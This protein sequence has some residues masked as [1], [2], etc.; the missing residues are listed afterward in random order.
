MRAQKSPGWLGW[1]PLVVLP[2]AACTVRNQLAPWQFM[3]LLSFA[4]FWGFKFETW[5][6]ARGAAGQAG[7]ARNLGY[8]SLW[9]GMDAPAFLASIRPATAP[10][11][12]DWLAATAK[13][14][15]GAAC[16]WLVAPRALSAHPLL[17]GWI[18]M[19]GLILML[20]F[21]TF[22]L[23]ALAWQFAG[24][25]AQPIMRSPV[26]ARSLSD[27]WGKR[28]NLGFRLLT[29]GLVFE[30]LAA[31]APRQPCSRRSSRLD[32]S[33]TSSFPF[34]RAAATAC[35]PPTLRCRESAC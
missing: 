4:V 7:I 31:L 35:R 33:T 20:H 34:P 22:H 18:G 29:H 19:L 15:T 32:S 27:F 11:A 30:P 16:I 17:G 25:D 5:F 24:V 9:P 3:W 12:S 8:L 10:R 14:L 1:V 23:L 2:A 6:R 28:W 21:G 13:T 26:S